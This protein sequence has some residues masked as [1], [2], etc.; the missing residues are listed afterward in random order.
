VKKTAVVSTC[1]AN[2]LKNGYI[3]LVVTRGAGS[4]GLNPY[5]CKRGEVIIIADSKYRTLCTG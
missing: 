5:L 3:R 1:K 2:R 4:L